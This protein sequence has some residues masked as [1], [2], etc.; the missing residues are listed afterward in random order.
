MIYSALNT[1]T[2]KSEL[3]KSIAKQLFSAQEVRV[4][5]MLKTDPCKKNP[6]L[7][8]LWRNHHIQ[9]IYRQPDEIQQEAGVFL[10]AKQL[11]HT[12]AMVLFL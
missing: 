4:R 9:Y 2:G 6:Q 10:M 1:S 3:E 12:R 11:C 7:I 5:G 8:F